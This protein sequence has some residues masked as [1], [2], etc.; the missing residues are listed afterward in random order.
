VFD[1]LHI[2]EWQP[3]GDLIERCGI[4]GMIGVD[5][6]DTI[7]VV[8][9]EGVRDGAAVDDEAIDSRAFRQIHE[10]P[11]R[12]H[13]HSAQLRL[14]SESRFDL[15]QCCPVNAWRQIPMVLERWDH[16]GLSRAGFGSVP[17]G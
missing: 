3:I 9:L 2:E 17:F 8:R 5:Q 11:K 6:E 13:L 16:F 7:D 1:Q 15:M 4:V 14:A 12:L 10:P